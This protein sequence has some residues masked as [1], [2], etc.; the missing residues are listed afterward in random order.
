VSERRSVRSEVEVAVDPATAFV[1]FTEEMDLWWRRGPINFYDAARAVARRCEPGV[2]G[3]LLEVYD[4]ATGDALELGR[5][6]AWEP[7]VRL[8][9]RSSL[10]D[11][12]TEVCF[13][14]AGAGTRVR[15]EAHVPVDGEDRGGTSWVRVTPAWFGSWCAR[16]EG[17]P[18]QAT[19][20]GRLGLAVYYAKPA[21]AA[22]WLQ[23]AF[24]FDAAGPLPDDDV[25]GE[26]RWIEFH[27]ANCSLILCKRDDDAFATGTAATH[28]PWVFV[29]QLD[30]HLA[31]AEAAGA[32]IVEP[33]HQHGYRAYVAEDPEGL[34]WTFAQARPTMH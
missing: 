11:V 10:D 6:T 4:E 20:L 28:V 27:V 13:D 15:V 33:I 9:W 2:G 1:A 24:G 17:A 5:F 25:E 22:R 23:S 34:R 16:R 29:D 19:D 18:R 26:R 8:G 3:R 21:R 30:A 14:P 7:G 12:V 32:R 31:R